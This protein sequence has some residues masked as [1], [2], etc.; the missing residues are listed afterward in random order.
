M[1]RRKSP[2][3]PVTVDEVSTA[4][5]QIVDEFGDQPLSW[6]TVQEAMAAVNFE[7]KTE[8]LKGR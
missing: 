8:A 6:E 7:A 5:L 1:R 3:E 2:A 4:I